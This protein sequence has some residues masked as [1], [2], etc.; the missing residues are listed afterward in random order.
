MMHHLQLASLVLY[1][2]NQYI[3]DFKLSYTIE[4]IR[5]LLVAPLLNDMGNATISYLAVVLLF[6][7]QVSLFLYMIIATALTQFLI[8]DVKQRLILERRIDVVN[9]VLHWFFTFYPV[10]FVIMACVC[11]GAV[12][13]N[14][15]GIFY[16]TDH[17]EYC[18]D[19]LISFF[20]YS[21]VVLAIIQ[22][23][24]LIYLLRNHRFA[25]N[26][27]FKR[28]FAFLQILN[29]LISFLMIIFHYN[30]KVNGTT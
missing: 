28:R 3:S 11:I 1:F 21:A 16:G 4:L 12:T 30:E 24:L 7:L 14:Q 22:G 23:I 9:S 17:P 2:P 20:A 29:F 6:I 10:F 27:S 5:P 13:C 19:S 25:E 26:N 18:T 8:N 15:V